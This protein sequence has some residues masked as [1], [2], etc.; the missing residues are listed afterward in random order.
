MTDKEV[1][2]QQN[3]SVTGF[4]QIKDKNTGEIIIQQRDG[5]V[6]P[7]RDPYGDKNAR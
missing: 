7:L 3:I 2:E 1:D 5:N 4:L 6:K